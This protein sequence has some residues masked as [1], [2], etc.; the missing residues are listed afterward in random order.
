MNGQKDWLRAVDFDSAFAGTP[1]EIDIAVMEAGRRIRRR[2]SHILRF[3]C[4]AAAVLV[5]AAGVS[6]LMLRREAHHPEDIVLTQPTANPED[7]Q[8]V[9]TGRRDAYYHTDAN[10]EDIMVPTVKM[11]RATAL[12]F[13]KMPCPACEEGNGE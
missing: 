12:E 6:A 11:Q 1:V 2:K 8:E 4:A 9:W 5:A 3:A 13:G 7:T 10:C